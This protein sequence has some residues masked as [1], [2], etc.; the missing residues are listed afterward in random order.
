MVV[1]ESSDVERVLALISEGVGVH[2]DQASHVLSTFKTA[3][4][5]TCVVS[6][7]QNTS[8]I[9]RLITYFILSSL[10]VDTVNVLSAWSV[11]S[12][13]ESSPAVGVDRGYI[14]IAFLQNSL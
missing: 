8:D 6:L 1:V 5:D 14:S 12:M 4:G 9:S 11:A 13:M 2:L 7:E 3:Y 10:R